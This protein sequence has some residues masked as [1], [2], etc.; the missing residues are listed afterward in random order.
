VD[1][2]RPIGRQ[3]ARGHDTVDVRMMLEALSPGVK[4]HESAN[5]HAQALRVGRDL[6]QR[7]RRGTKHEVVDDAFIGQRETRSGLGW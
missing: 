2:L 7:R 4:D 1:P 6:Q 3:S 5:R